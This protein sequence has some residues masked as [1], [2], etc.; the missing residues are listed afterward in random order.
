MAEDL[1]ADGTRPLGGAP[2]DLEGGGGAEKAMDGWSRDE[3][4]RDN[5]L[6]RLIQDL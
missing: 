3:L 2:A 5:E 1:A 6:L 4:C